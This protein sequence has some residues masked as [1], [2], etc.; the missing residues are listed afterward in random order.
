MRLLCRPERNNAFQQP[1]DVVN[2]VRSYRELIHILP[3]RKC[4]LLYFLI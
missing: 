1:I 3:V 4:D 2:N